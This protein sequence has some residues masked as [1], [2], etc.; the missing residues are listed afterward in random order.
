MEIEID[1]GNDGFKLKAIIC[2]DGDQWCVLFGANI[3][4]GIAGFGGS[5]WEAIM[6]F[7][8]EFRNS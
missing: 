5:T 3:Q 6:N 4:D 2:K 7:K 8:Q 1:F